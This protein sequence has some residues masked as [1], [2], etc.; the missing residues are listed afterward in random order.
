MNN[1]I[2]KKQE[3]FMAYKNKALIRSKDILCYGNM[4][5]KYIV[6]LEILSKEKVKGMDVGN[7][8]SMAL[9][10][11]E[12]LASNPSAMFIEHCEK[13]KLIDALETANA[14]ITL[15]EKT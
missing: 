5:D 1:D 2:E 8:I 4:D 13:N 14:W 9:F 10:D 7:K 12:E 3:K 11:R 6:L 15:H